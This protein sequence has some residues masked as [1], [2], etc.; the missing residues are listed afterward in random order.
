M[1]L[2]TSFSL[3]LVTA[4]VTS[5]CHSACHGTFESPSTGNRFGTD[6][7]KLPGKDADAAS[8]D[9]AAA[10]EGS[11]G[12]TGPTAATG[13]LITAPAISR[14]SVS[15]ASLPSGGGMVTLEWTVSGADSLT[16]APLVGVV[17]GTTMR[18]AI[19]STTMFTLTA[20]NAVA[21]TSLSATVSVSVPDASP[22]EPLWLPV[23]N[24]ARIK[25]PAQHMHFTAGLPF[26]ILAD[27]V[28]TDEWQCAPGHPPYCCA[29]SAMD[30]F[31][32]AAKVGTVPMSCSEQNHWELRLPA[33]LPAGDH[34]LTVR[35]HPHGAPAI[36]GFVPVYIHVDPLPSHANTVSLGADLVLTGSTPLVWDDALVIGNGHKVTAAAGFSGN[37]TITNSL[38]TGLAAFDDQ[39]GIDV[40]TTGSV[41]LSHD[42]FEATA[43]VHLAVNGAGSVTIE[44]NELR[45]NN[46]VTFVSHDPA[47]S[48][49]LRVSGT[50]TGAKRFVGNNVAAGIV[51]LVGMSGW[52]IGGLSS[53]LGN[54]FIG[55]RCVL[56]LVGSNA[57]VIQGNYLHHDYYGGFSQGFNLYFDGSDG[58]LAEHNVIRQ[59]SW[60]VQSFGGELRYNLLVDSGH[61]FFRSMR[62]G[63]S[64]HHNVIVHAAAPNSGFD[65]GVFT[66]GGESGLSFYNNTFDVGGASAGFD[67]PAFVFSAASVTSIRNNVFTGFSSLSGRWSGGALVSGASQEATVGVA[68][69]GSADYNLWHNPLSAALRYAPGLV[70]GAAG[71]HDKIASPALAGGGPEAPFRID[72]GKVWL[73]TFSTADVLAHYRAL[74]AP[75]GGSPLIDAGDPADGAGTDIGAVGAGIVDVDDAFGRVLTP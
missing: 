66:Y 5:A 42:V 41:R 48:P 60:P 13:S 75:A 18:V 59:G 49:V 58:A 9:P 57:A 3:L 50:A 61:D 54:V 10:L 27:G 24:Q 8:P 52:Q 26:R 44:N 68:R 19:A 23:G 31:V 64:I 12:A 53:A 34:T 38:I 39:I 46:F 35:F 56:S 7:P 36:D 11:T 40:T 15:P 29:D 28:G 69:V 67:A 2:G 71:A 6:S 14:F 37:V 62:D 47:K 70:A 21:A 74:Y 30:F 73:R 55:P 45:A 17:T 33:G 63:T 16:I 1:K 72:E 22:I 65:G 4:I 51:E 43:P 32:D 20:T 25:S